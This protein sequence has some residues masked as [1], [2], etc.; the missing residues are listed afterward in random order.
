MQQCLLKGIERVQV[1]DI[2]VCNS[3]RDMIMM[4]MQGLL[5][6]GDE[7]LVPAPDYPLW[8]AAVNLSGG[9]RLFTTSATRHR[10]SILT[11]KIWIQG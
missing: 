7:T 2:Y 5:N 1:E 10:S 9:A 6:D 11:S 4:A 8:T 3:L